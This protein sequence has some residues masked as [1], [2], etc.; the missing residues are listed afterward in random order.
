MF[1]SLFPRVRPSDESDVDFSDAYQTKAYER[2]LDRYYI[3]DQMPTA[4]FGITDYQVR[5][6]G[7]HPVAYVYATIRGGVLTAVGVDRDES[8][9]ALG[10]FGRED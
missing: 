10:Y 1:D 8:L 6:I 3:G 2:M 7:G 4:P 9:P 5:V